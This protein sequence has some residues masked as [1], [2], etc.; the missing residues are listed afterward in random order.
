[1]MIK[2]G[3]VTNNLWEENKLRWLNN[4]PTKPFPSFPTQLFPKRR[5]GE[6]QMATSDRRLHNW[7]GPW[8]NR[9][10]F[11]FIFWISKQCHLRSSW[12]VQA[13]FYC[14]VTRNILL[15]MP[16]S[17][18]Q[19]LCACWSSLTAPNTTFKGLFSALRIAVASLC[20]TRDRLKSRTVSL[21][22]TWR[23]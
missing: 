12:M 23:P 4:N 6:R 17:P 9:N 19:Y 2:L 3:R 20:W 18:P 15:S 11:I 21:G 13:F 14:T 5:K 22:A 10:F 7:K 16:P 1:M 8:G